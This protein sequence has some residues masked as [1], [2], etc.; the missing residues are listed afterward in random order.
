MTK[1]WNDDLTRIRATADYQF[2]RKVG[3]KLFPDEVKIIHSSRTGRIR[4]IY[5][6][7][8]RLATLRPTDGLLSLSLKGAKR[9]LEQT[10]DAR[11]LV[12]VKDDVGKFVAEGGDVFSAHVV[13]ADEELRARDEVI[14]TNEKGELLAVGRAVLSSGEM[15]MF[16][17]GVAVKTRH[18]LLQKKTSSIP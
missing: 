16:R 5:L 7:Q 1:I 9:I 4:Y 10:K 3:S 8:E 2:G 11:C 14:V 18:G 13:R 6:G 17:R 15:G 12:K